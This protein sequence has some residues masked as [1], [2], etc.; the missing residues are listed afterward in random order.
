MREYTGLMEGNRDEVALEHSVAVVAA[1]SPQPRS[2]SA[3]RTASSSDCGGV[4]RGA[5]A[6]S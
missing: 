5:L 4:N 6:V 2:R 1:L 3:T